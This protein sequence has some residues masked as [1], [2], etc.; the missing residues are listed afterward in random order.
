MSKPAVVLLLVVGLL[1]TASPAALFEE[2]L[3]SA[4]CWD[5]DATSDLELTGEFTALR[6]AFA[7]GEECGEDGVHGGLADRS[8]GIHALAPVLRVLS[9]ASHNANRSREPAV[10][11]GRSPPA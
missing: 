6:H 11:H 5:V 7:E 8:G 9:T 10:I 4:P 1:L 3:G 2:G